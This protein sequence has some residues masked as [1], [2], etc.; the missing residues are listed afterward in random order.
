LSGQN[1]PWIA[2]A[3]IPENVQEAN[4][5]NLG[6]TSTILS[7]PVALKAKRLSVLAVV[8]GS[9]KT[10]VG[11]PVS[12]TSWTIATIRQR[13]VSSANSTGIEDGAAKA[14]ASTILVFIG[15]FEG[16]STGTDT[17]IVNGCG[18]VTISVTVVSVVGRQTGA[19]FDTVP[20]IVDNRSPKAF[21]V[22]VFVEIGYDT[23][24]S[25]RANS[26][27]VYGRCSVAYTCTI[28]SLLVR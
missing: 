3:G 1:V 23:R 9:S 25:T 21:S 11:L 8:L 7:W 24:C 20:T 17:T 5:T 22:A 12:C 4:S 13:T 14:Y 15:N 26:A 18:S 6:I 19:S 27:I 10:V 16:V 2:L 28:L